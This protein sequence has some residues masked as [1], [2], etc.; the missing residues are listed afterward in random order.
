M[1]LYW[2][3]NM[4]VPVLIGVCQQASSGGGGGAI[5][6]SINQVG[7]QNAQPSPQGI[8]TSFATTAN[9]FTYPV[10][11]ADPPTGLANTI[12]VGGGPFQQAR[13]AWGVRFDS[14]PFDG[15]QSLFGTGK[16]LDGAASGP[17]A[18][19]CAKISFDFDVSGTGD[20]G[21]IGELSQQ[22]WWAYDIFNEQLIPKITATPTKIEFIFTSSTQVSLADC[23]PTGGGDVIIPF[24]IESPLFEGPIAYT[25]DSGT[26]SA[27]AAGIFFQ[28]GE[29]GFDSEFLG[30]S[31]LPQTVTLTFIAIDGT[32]STATATVNWIASPVPFDGRSLIQELIFP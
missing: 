30:V 14:T 2:V 28:G 27:I 25:T 11:T 8:S 12:S 19:I 29:V 31:S 3:I 13:Y 1:G 20:P 21:G 15:N 32:E 5:T 4:G 17:N 26:T 16:T 7:G 6:F 10:A 9:S 24:G 18:G 22:L 23:F